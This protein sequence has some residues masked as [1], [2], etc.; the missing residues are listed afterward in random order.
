[1][2]EELRLSLLL[3]GGFFIL[4]VLAHGL[5]NIRKN[6][7]AKKPQRRS[8]PE[9]WQDEKRDDEQSKGARDINGF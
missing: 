4:G 1:M 7:Q 6:S 9:G 5:W 2:E 3:L 8:E